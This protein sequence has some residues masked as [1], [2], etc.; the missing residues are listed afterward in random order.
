MHEDCNGNYHSGTYRVFAQCS[1]GYTVVGYGDTEAKCL[2]DAQ[3]WLDKRE[4]YLRK[5]DREKLEILVS[6]DLL[7]SDKKEAIRII[8]KII[9]NK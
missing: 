2:A 1:D 6:G 5:S 3:S 7:D 9:L 8:A 4:E